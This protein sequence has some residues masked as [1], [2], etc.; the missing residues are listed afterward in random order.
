MKDRE[1]LKCVMIQSKIDAG[2]AKRVDNI[3]N[4]YGFG[5]RYELMQYILSSFLRVADPDGEITEDDV[6]MA[7]YAKMFEGFEN[8][9]N[10]IITTKPGGN[11]ALKL[12][13]SINI[14][15]EIGR[16]GYVNVNL[17]IQGEDIHT[18]RSSCKALEVIMKKLY[19]RVYNGLLLIGDEIGAD[20]IVRVIEM[21]V[22][23]INADDIE[24]GEI[25]RELGESANEY[26]KVYVR[27]NNREMV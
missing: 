4:K 16:K 21:L 27:H 5:S 26:G 13:D 25:A 1:K 11:K 9:K 22:S 14:Y 2:T 10:R 20:S 6:R 3:V 18:N 15:S 7:E 23:R 17:K 24:R 8:A 19:P 12:T